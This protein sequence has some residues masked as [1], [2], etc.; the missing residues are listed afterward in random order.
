LDFRC[1]FLYNFFQPIII[2]QINLS[3]AVVFKKIQE[4]SK[5]L[6]NIFVCKKC[7]VTIILSIICMNPIYI[8]LSWLLIV[9][10]AINIVKGG[11]SSLQSCSRQTAAH[12]KSCVLK[13]HNYKFGPA[14]FG[15]HK[16]KHQIIRFII[17]SGLPHLTNHYIK[18]LY[19]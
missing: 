8:Y 3:Y 7:N 6:F 5:L 10:R 16:I 12:W 15:V 13:L 18:S 2:K 17:F 11:K 14:Y 4:L 9:I 19:I 1:Y